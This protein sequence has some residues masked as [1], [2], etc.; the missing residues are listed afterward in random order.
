MTVWHDVLCITAV[1]SVGVGRLLQ[2]SAGMN[3]PPWRTIFILCLTFEA[4]LF[5][6]T[7]FLH[8]RFSDRQSISGHFAIPCCFYFLYFVSLFFGEYCS[9]DRILKLWSTSFSSSHIQELICRLTFSCKPSDLSGF[10]FNW[11]VPTLFLLYLTLLSRVTFG[12]RRL[13]VLV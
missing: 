6:T 7:C 2:T 10:F 1:V 8:R 12:G 9:S 13:C 11:G 3:A 5:R 4:R